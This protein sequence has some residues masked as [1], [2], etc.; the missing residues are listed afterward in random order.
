MQIRTYTGMSLDG[1]MAHADGLP[2]WDAM[3]TF[4]PGESHGY[5]EFSPQCP[6]IIIGRTVFDF[7]HMYWT[8]HSM[9]PWAD[10]QVYVLTSHPLPEKRHADVTASKGG[11]AELIH[12]LRDA[13]IPG[14]VQLLGGGRTIRAF[15]EIGAVDEFGITIL[16]L[17]LGDGVPLF[18]PGTLP[19]SP[20]R[21]EH[22]QTF[23]D[24][25]VLLVYRKES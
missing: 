5:K 8:E 22:H 4:V 11:P 21:L 23:P 19:Q 9:W 20:L 13:D 24:G 3:P 18:A 16:P 1:F 17:L 15:L 10:K 25:A 6:A 2:V 12:Q 14:D 7:G